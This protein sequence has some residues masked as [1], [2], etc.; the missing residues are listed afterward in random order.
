MHYQLRI[1]GENFAVE[2]GTLQAGTLRVSVN[3]SP[4]DVIVVQ[5]ASAAPIATTAAPVRQAAAEAAPAPRPAAEAAAGAVLAPIPGLIVAV[6]VQVG[7]A[8]LA[9]QTVAMMEAMKMENNLIAPVDGVVSE[10]RVQKGS[11]V[12]TGDVILRIG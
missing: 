8:V 11:E 10:I 1:A 7:D 6:M 4:F 9:G 12:A 3:G 5:D 2:V